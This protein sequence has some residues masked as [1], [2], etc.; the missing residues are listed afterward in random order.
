MQ[1]FLNVFLRA[2]TAGF[3]VLCHGGIVLGTT[4]FV[5]GA[6]LQT[7]SDWIERAALAG[8]LPGLL[9]WGWL[10]YTKRLSKPFRRWLSLLFVQVGSCLI[11]AL[12]IMANRLLVGACG[13]DYLYSNMYW[14][15]YVQVERLLVALLVAALISLFAAWLLHR[16]LLLA[17]GGIAT[18]FSVV[19]VFT[20][21][22][23]H[24]YLAFWTGPRQAQVRLLDEETASLSEHLW[25]PEASGHAYQFFLYRHFRAEAAGITIRLRADGTGNVE[26][27]IVRECHYPERLEMREHQFDLTQSE[28]RHLLREVREHRFW[29][30]SQD[31]VDTGGLHGSSWHFRAVRDGNMHEIT[32]KNPISRSFFLELEERMNGRELYELGVF[33]LECGGVRTSKGNLY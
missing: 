4:H 18:F 12:I 32:V 11:C 30:I 17:R 23:S 22:Y 20:I 26:T 33:F 28:V 24:S 9:S 14:L 6:P 29:E 31:S 5:L 27:V 1:S 8:V 21:A 19:M 15:P 16:E 7:T 13:S 10:C 3:T 25:I 2:L